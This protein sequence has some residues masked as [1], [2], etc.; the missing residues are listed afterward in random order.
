[1]LAGDKPQYRLHAP[2]AYKTP[3]PSDDPKTADESP[4]ANEDLGVFDVVVVATPLVSAG[5]TI[6]GAEGTSTPLQAPPLHMQT[7]ISTFVEASLREGAWQ[8]HHSTIRVGEG[9]TV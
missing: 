9:R 2:G 7:T 4:A 1:M 6:V 8:S 5:L 3:S